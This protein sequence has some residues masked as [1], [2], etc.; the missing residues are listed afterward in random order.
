MSTDDT[1]AHIDHLRS[2]QDH[3]Q[4]SADHMR[5]LSVLRRL[6]ARLYDHEA[7]TML[8]RA[9]SARHDE[10]LRHGNTHLPAPKAGEHKTMGAEHADKSR[11]HSKLMEAIFALEKDLG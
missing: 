2:E 10:A 8:H 5:A 3:L 4:W 7:H 6:E 11:H 1:Q 9:E